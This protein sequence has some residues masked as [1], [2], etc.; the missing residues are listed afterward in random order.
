[1][2]AV[3]EISG[4]QQIVRPDEILKVD[5]LTGNAGDSITINNVLA[6]GEGESISFGNPYIEGVS[7]VFEA[8][9][10]QKDRKVIVFKKKRRKRYEVKRGHR[11]HLSV[12][13][14]KEINSNSI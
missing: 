4:K 13:K 5:R 12:V 14:V 6:L 1:M 10:N 7:V 9:E 11:Q 2:Y 8:L 3:V